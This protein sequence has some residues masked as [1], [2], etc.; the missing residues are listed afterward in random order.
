MQRQGHA[1]TLLTHL[2]DENDAAGLPV[3]LETETEI[4]VD[5]YKRFGFE[6]IR[7]ITLPV[8]KLPMWL[9]VREPQQ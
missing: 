6:V 2:L 7:E 1:K 3:Y 5:I 9:M 4:N 8:I